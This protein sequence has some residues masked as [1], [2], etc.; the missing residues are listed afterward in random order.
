MTS[1]LNNISSYIERIRWSW[2][3]ESRNSREG[4]GIVIWGRC[5]GV[6][7]GKS[8]AFKTGGNGESC[9]SGST[10]RQADK[11]YWELHFG[12]R[13]DLLSSGAILYI[14]G[15]FQ[16]REIPVQETPPN[17]S[18]SLQGPNP[19]TKPICEN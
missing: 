19:R 5:C 18:E 7:S 12:E 3:V 4:A 16:Q 8:L 14:P 17:C 6:Y 9:P 15:D 1:L 11:Q 13:G 2:M 10:W